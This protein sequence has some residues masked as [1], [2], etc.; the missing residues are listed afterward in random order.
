MATLH[1]ETAFYKANETGSSNL[2]Y[3]LGHKRKYNAKQ[4][5]HLGRAKEEEVEQSHDHSAQIN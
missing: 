4:Q 3:A 5:T 2:M 1:A